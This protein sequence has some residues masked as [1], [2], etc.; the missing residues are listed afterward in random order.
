MEDNSLEMLVLYQR[1]VQCY[2]QPEPE[3]HDEGFQLL[4]ETAENGLT[5][6]CKML[7]LLY[8]SGQYAPY[9]EIDESMAVRCW[10]MAAESGDEEA[11][12]WLGQC[13]E[14][15]IGV[16][17]NKEEA[18]IWKKFAVDNGFVAEGD[19]AG[20][21]P[22]EPEK[23][24]VIAPKEEK[25]KSRKKEKVKAEKKVKNEKKTKKP[26]LKT[27][28]KI[29]ER[30]EEKTAKKEEVK[31]E[32]TEKER[33]WLRT[34]VQPVVTEIRKQSYQLK[35]VDKK[36]EEEEAEALRFARQEE[37]ARR[38]SNLYRLRMGFGGA[39]CCLLFLWI[40]LLLGYWLIRDSGKGYMFVFWTL[41]GL[42]SAS[43]VLLG[44]NVGVKKAQKRIEMVAEYRKTAFYHAYGCELGQ[45]TR[46]QQWCYKI[47]RSLAK[48]YFPVTYRR[49]VDLPEL[50]GY[51]GC[52][53][54]NW[55][56][57]SENEKAQPEF[58]IVTEKAVYVIKTEYLTGRVQGDLAD[59]TWS[60]FS[61][62]EKDMTA[63]RIPNLVDENAR[64][65]RIIKEDLV[66]YFD[67]PLEQIPFYNVIFLNEEVDTKGLRRMA[68]EDDTVF[69]Q[70]FSDKLRGGLGV[71]ES[72]L[73]THNMGLDE[74]IFAFEQIGRQFIKRNGW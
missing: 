35:E 58:V 51:R 63:E 17:V 1:A 24:D 54:T 71:W 50:R 61:N 68:A 43:C 46:Q 2:Q 18:R 7:G 30:I 38:V 70:G 64:N 3:K 21:L 47:Y 60:L 55:V 69:V 14:D 22:A 33:K 10:R 34:P 36:K 31:T 53:Y 32:S 26:L 6:A 44:Y 8:M 59:V 20:E 65:I 45:M 74:L 67:L 66:Q 40:V 42:L 16:E 72:R 13:Y 11:M 28:Q 49:K 41:S 56:Y 48:N 25:Y 9:P 73:P 29:S 12:F 57:Q 52:L 15:G 27:V 5:P 19:E 39:I 4:L 37:E 62:G 23:A